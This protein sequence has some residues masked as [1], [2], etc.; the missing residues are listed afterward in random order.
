CGELVDESA[1]SDA[2]KSGKV[3]GAALDVFAT[4]PPP[5]AYPLFEANGLMAT[6]HIAGSTE[7]AQETVGIRIAEQ[8]VEYLKNGGDLTDANM[9]AVSRE[10]YRALSPYV[11]LA[12]GLGILTAHIAT[13]NPQTVRLVYFG[14]IAGG[15]TNLLRNAGV[16]GA[17]GRS[18]PHRVNLVN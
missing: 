12:E 2:L 14:K 3:A 17:L 4:E 16:A 1:L 6:P 15:N 13:G 7:E 10:Q 9:P 8:V 5:A 11:T 18:T